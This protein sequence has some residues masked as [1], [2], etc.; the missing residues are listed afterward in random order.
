MNAFS[1]LGFCGVL[2]AN[3]LFASENTGKTNDQSGR[4]SSEYEY[5]ELMVSPSA[6]E[7]LS[8][9]AKS[10]AKNSWKAHWTFESSAALTLVAGIL[11]SSDPGKK[12]DL[13]DGETAMTK[14][15]SMAAFS[16]GGG[17]LALSAFLSTSYSPY[18]SGVQD[19]ANTGRG[20]T[21]RD[22]L[23][24]ER[25]AEEALSRPARISKVLKWASFVTNLAAGGLV[26]GSAK[27][28]TTKIAGGVAVIGSFLPLMFE[29]PWA[30]AD[31]FQEDYKKRIYGP[32]VYHNVSLVPSGSRLAAEWSV[33]TRF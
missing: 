13:P 16:I 19:L 20:T 28:D 26:A 7:R 6:S 3:S 4:I 29:H 9:E 18:K 32:L 1:L 25:R 27:N 11:S 2:I 8:Q 5:P 22:Q 17:W 30:E 33:G 10:E 15:A 31:R 23:A 21:K 24:Y 14:T 12:S